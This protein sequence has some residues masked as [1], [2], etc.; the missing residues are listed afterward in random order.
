MFKTTFAAFIG[1]RKEGKVGKGWERLGCLRGGEEKKRVPR[2]KNVQA[3][4]V[5]FWDVCSEFEGGGG[6]R[7]KKRGEGKEELRRGWLNLIIGM[8]E[9]FVRLFDYSQSSRN[10]D[11]D[12]RSRNYKNRSCIVPQTSKIKPTP[13]DT[14]HPLQS[15]Q[16]NLFHDMKPFRRVQD[17]IGFDQ[18]LAR[19]VK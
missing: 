1:G 9:I 8:G 19:R 12:Y 7:E 18:P 3:D 5:E 10:F 4:K 14:A 6:E 2:M 13:S 15:S 11:K 17:R 16:S